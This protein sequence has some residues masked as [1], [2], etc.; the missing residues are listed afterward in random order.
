MINKRIVFLG[1]P[2]ISAYLLD[3]MVKAGFN[4]VGVIT[5]EDKPQGRKMELKPSAVG[6]TAAR[7]GLKVFKPHKLNKEYSFLEE[8]QPDLLLTFAYGQLISTAVLAYSKFSPLNFHASILPKYR[9]AAPIQYALKNGETET[10]ISLMEM[11]KEMDAGDVFA[12]EK[13]P[14]GK[15]DNYSS[16]CLK[17]QELALQMAVKYLPL[18]FDNKLV[19]TKQDETKVTFCPSIKKEEEHLVLAQ[20]P[21][22]FVNQV[23]SLADIPGGYLTLGDTMI[24]IYKASINDQTEQ[25]SIGTIVSAQKKSIILQ[26]QGGTVKLLI[27]QKPGKKALDASSFL[28]GSHDLEGKILL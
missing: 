24:K 5:R 11:I 17:L 22:G 3:G 12:V 10:G 9:G 27:L 15:D 26:L 1:T 21:E 19:R 2:A 16:M 20:S 18:F 28:N 25:A 13:L 7:L 4:I 14:I 23:R 8:L 6:E